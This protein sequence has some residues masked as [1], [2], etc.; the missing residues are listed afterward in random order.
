MKRSRRSRIATQLLVWFLLLTLVPLIVAAFLT[1]RTA[2]S[3]L[4][5]QIQ[6]NL[7]TIADNLGR[8]VDTFLRGQERDLLVLAANPGTAEAIDAFAY[9]WKNGTLDEAA[10]DA[11]AARFAALGRHATPEEVADPVAFLCSP[12]ASYIT[13]AN[14]RIDGSALKSANF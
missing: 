5:D 6:T 1:T 13:G 9:A 8:Q 14:L 3:L 2:R 10:H 11:A 4:T 7:R 12:L